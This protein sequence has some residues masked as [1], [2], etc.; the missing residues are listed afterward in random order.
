MTAAP[1]PSQLRSECWVE[2]KADE[3]CWA[4]R[5][6][7]MKQFR[8]P[9]E[10]PLG[11]EDHR[12]RLE[13][14]AFGPLWARLC[15]AVFLDERPPN[16]LV[17]DTLTKAI[18]DVPESQL[19][20]W[21][22]GLLVLDA[23][24]RS[25]QSSQVSWFPE[26][27]D[28]LLATRRTQRLAP[29]LYVEKRLLDC[30]VTGPRTSDGQGV[31]WA[32]RRR[33]LR[34]EP[35]ASPGTADGQWFRIDALVEYLP[36]WEAVVHPKC[37]FYQD[38]YMVKWGPPYNTVDYSEMEN[39]SES[40]CGATWE[41]DECIPDQMDVFKV[42]A[43]RKWIEMQ[44]ER[45]QR[46]ASQAAMVMPQRPSG[47]EQEGQVAKKQKIFNPKK[48]SLNRDC[49]HPFLGHAVENPFNEDVDEAHI[50]KGWPK[51]AEEHPPGHTSASPPGFCSDTCSCMEDWH[52]GKIP[53]AG[54]DHLANHTRDAMAIKV[55]QA[56]QDISG[57]VRKRGLVTRRYYLEPS[58]G[59][60]NPRPGMEVEAALRDAAKGIHRIIEQAAQ[61]LPLLGLRDKKGAGTI[62][63]VGA[64]L[65]RRMPANNQEE[66]SGGHGPYTPNRYRLAGA[67]PW[68]SVWPHTGDVNVNNDDVPA[69]LQKK[70][71]PMQLVISTPGMAEE[72]V[73]ISIDPVAKPNG[74]GA[75][76]PLTRD[77][78]KI[79][80]GM[81]PK[82]RTLLEARLAPIYDFS[83]KQCRPAHV[84]AWVKAVCDIELM[85]RV[86]AAA[87]VL[88]S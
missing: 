53:E 19:L 66:F 18:Y 85:L 61:H 69:L 22:E 2:K 76:E 62:A 87:H 6:L 43:K 20:P 14:A 78:V 77:V 82:Y 81:A 44:R 73:K 75:F 68:L 29:S 48:L 55:V 1:A 5:S 49:A 74:G 7:D 52:L 84:N 10:L 36:P 32:H 8:D 25:N 40:L 15:P 71:M 86:G 26:L 31:T 35:P 33:P 23:L 58:N 83:A 13:A 67:P 56:F 12:Q 28:I 64:V 54:K 88:P 65:A 37:G 39:G 27:N 9:A 34:K 79:L 24:S 47:V 3:K 4:W 63:A 57:H 51:K 17:R 70:A 41:P 42:R 59:P 50:K 46:P 21:Y 16:L 72:T 60:S 38:F 45:E 11:R 30:A 80:Q